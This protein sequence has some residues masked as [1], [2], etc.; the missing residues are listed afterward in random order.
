LGGICSSGPPAVHTLPV[1]RQPDPF[2][3]ALVIVD[4]ETFQQE[5]EYGTEETA[6]PAG[7]RVIF[8]RVGP[9]TYDEE[10]VEGLPVAARHVIFTN[11]TNVP[12]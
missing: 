11:S 12:P 7:V 3:L 4:V 5:G 2:S 8:L 6:D 10:V 9:H 1:C